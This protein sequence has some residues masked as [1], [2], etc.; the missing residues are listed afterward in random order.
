MTDMTLQRSA[1]LIYVNN[2]RRRGHHVCVVDGHG[3]TALSKGHS[4]RCL[5]LE[6]SINSS[7]FKVYYR[8]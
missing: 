8:H 7:D 6:P 3:Y 5:S 2:E 1:K 4:A